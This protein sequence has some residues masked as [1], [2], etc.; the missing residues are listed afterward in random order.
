MYD[1]NV[2]LTYD[3]LSGVYLNDDE[4]SEKYKRE[5]VREFEQ[6]DGGECHACAN[7]GEQ[8]FYSFGS[9]ASVEGELSCDSCISK[10]YEGESWD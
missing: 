9:T 2:W 1:I 5:P 3:P 8:Y 4:L 10:W 6:Y 7:C